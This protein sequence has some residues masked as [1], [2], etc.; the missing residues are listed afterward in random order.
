MHA[1]IGA[2]RGADFNPRLQQLRKDAFEVARDGAL[3]GLILK[4]GE[5][6]AVILDDG[7]KCD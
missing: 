1:G 6:R 4:A 2:P 5:I 7:T 3:L